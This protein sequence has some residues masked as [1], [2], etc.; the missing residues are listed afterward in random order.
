LF[1]SLSAITSNVQSAHIHNDPNLQQANL[2]PDTDTTTPTSTIMSIPNNVQWPFVPT[3]NSPIFFNP[4]PGTQNPPAYIGPWVYADRQ[5]RKRR[6]SETYSVEDIPPRAK[7]HQNLST[8]A[9]YLTE[10]AHLARKVRVTLSLLVNQ[11]SQRFRISDIGDHIIGYLALPWHCLQ[12]WRHKWF[13]A[14]SRGER[15]C[16]HVKEKDRMGLR[17]I[18]DVNR[19]FGRVE[20]FMEE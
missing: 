2:I 12:R 14:E 19:F 3:D 9:S 16:R 11:N 5:T 15:I 13:A 6:H 10:Q 4:E 8:Y 1:G 18:R 20:R 7:S 17:R